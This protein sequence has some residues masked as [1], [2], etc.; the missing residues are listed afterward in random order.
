[1][2][3]G[4]PSVV[5]RLAGRGI[6][7]ER[8]VAVHRGQTVQVRDFTITG[9]FAR[10]E[11]AGFLAEDALG[12]L[13]EVNGLRIYH[14]GD[15]EY[16]ARLRPVAEL[17]PDV[18]MLCMNGSGGCM[19]AHEAALL[20]WHLASRIVY[21]NHFG[22]WAPEHYGPGA[23]LDPAQFT[24]TYRR[25]GGTGDVRIPAVGVCELLDAQRADPVAHN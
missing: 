6:A 8:I 14:S 7:S 11:V 10:H 5:A 13:L 21:P 3:V 20:A 19:N 17:C 15:T 25:L 22:M 9:T 2:F 16:D 1:V 18:A 23:T 24:R 4:P 12:L